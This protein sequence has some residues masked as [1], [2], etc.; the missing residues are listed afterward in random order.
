MLETNLRIMIKKGF[1]FLIFLFLINAQTFGQKNTLPNKPNELKNLLKLEKDSK[2]RIDILAALSLIYQKKFVF[3]SAINYRLEVVKL[4]E[5]YA[6]NDTLFS[7]ITANNLLKISR[8]YLTT[9][10]FEQAIKYST[11]AQQFVKSNKGLLVF[12]YA[13]KAEV[14]RMYA[15]AG[16][17]KIDES[18]VYYDSLTT[19]GRMAYPDA[20]KKRIA[21]D[22]GYCDY[23]NVKNDTKNALKYI[24][25]A[26][27][28]ALNYADETLKSQIKYMYG[29]TYFENKKYEAALPLLLEAEKTANTWSPDLYVELQRSIARCYGAMGNWQKAYIFYDKFAPL[30]DSIYVKAA[31]SSLADAEAK[32]Q[33]KEKQAQIEIKNLQL[34]QNNTQKKWYLAG[35]AALLVA[36]GLLF[37]IFKTKQKANVAINEKNQVLEKLN[38]ELTEANQTKA[39]LFGII[40]HDLRSPISQ[41]YQYLKLQE[42]NPNLLNEKQK[43]DLSGKIQTATGSLLETMED[44]LLWSKTQLSQFNINIQKVEIKPI[45]DQSIQLLKLNIEAKNLNVE[46][47]IHENI[48]QNTDPYFLQIIIRNL[49][50]N[51]IKASPESSKIIIDF[52]QNQIT[53]QNKGEIFTHSQYRAV[54]E[55]NQK[56]ETLSGLG[57]KL[58]DELSQK[59]GVQINFGSIDNDTLVKLDF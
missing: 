54:I 16:L 53:M 20:W 47:L 37:W 19:I 13:E 27:S 51:A 14:L 44:L 56:Q 17:K 48:K 52:A 38:N 42:L 58:V 4:A 7:S 41:V 12:Y 21:L 10:Q 2:T 6:K 9:G 50:Q 30:R 55:G 18:K 24:K 34:A 59:I 11:K 28:L 46:N 23:F 29:S 49:L 43:T 33:N 25:S 5:K 3:D 26:D 31:E 57:L 36:L 35:L 32:F 40:S 45:I 1:F 22:L 15:Q 39:K 8:L